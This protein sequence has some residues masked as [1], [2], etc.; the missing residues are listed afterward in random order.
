MSITFKANLS[1]RLESLYTKQLQRAKNTSS[2]NIEENNQ[3]QNM[4]KA[5]NNIEK[6]FP[7]DEVDL[8]ENREGEEVLTINGKQIQNDLFYRSSNACFFPH[9]AYILN[10]ESKGVIVPALSYKGAFLH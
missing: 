4:L 5:K 7:N 10:A 6:V 3:L 1:P 8:F 2:K 9:I